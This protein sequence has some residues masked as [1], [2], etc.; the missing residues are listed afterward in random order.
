MNSSVKSGDTSKL[1]AAETD[2]E[3]VSKKDDEDTPILPAKLETLGIPRHPLKKDTSNKD[4]EVIIQ[5]MELDEELGLNQQKFLTA[6]KALEKDI[7]DLT[8]SKDYFEVSD[9]V[10]KKLFQIGSLQRKCLITNIKNVIK[11]FLTAGALPLIVNFIT[12]ALIYPMISYSRW[13]WSASFENPT[14]GMILLDVLNVLSWIGLV[15]IL[16][17]GIVL[18]SD[19]ELKATLLSVKLKATPLREVGEEIPYG[20]KL[21]VL[22]AKRTKIFEDFIY[23]TPEFEV[24]NIKKNIFPKLPNIDP[25]ILGV[26]MDN[27]KFMVVYWDIK[28]DIEKVTRQIEHFKKFK[29]NKE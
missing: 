18:W 14:T 24:K 2:Y 6:K 8:S 16:I 27:R 4:I 26:T 9:D 21:K 23:V 28:K 17:V 22:E 19:K 5:E 13:V 10:I 29:L 7:D 3:E 1:K 12:L 11:S 25:A 20:A 15:V